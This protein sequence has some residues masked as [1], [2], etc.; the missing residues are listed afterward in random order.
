[1]GSVREKIALLKEKEASNRSLRPVIPPRV[2]PLVRQSSLGSNKPLVPNRPRKTN[3][4]E[5]SRDIQPSKISELTARLN[6][7]SVPSGAKPP[8]AAQVKV[9]LEAAKVKDDEVIVDLLDDD[10]D[11]VDLE[12]D[13]QHL[14]LSRPKLVV[15]RRRP[16]SLKTVALAALCLPKTKSMT[17]VYSLP[18]DSEVD[19][20]LSNEMALSRP[21]INSHLRRRPMGFQSVAI[22]ALRDRV[23]EQNDVHAVIKV[24][25]DE[26]AS[27]SNDSTSD[28]ET[29]LEEANNETKSETKVE[30]QQEDDSSEYTSNISSDD[31]ES[32]DNNSFQDSTDDDDLL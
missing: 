14:S 25:V 10:K 24:I 20:S 1:M 26:I 30:F 31:E 13:M 9:N 27:K 12:E 23:R 29:E 28:V 2:D 6:L 21:K 3:D 18:G 11:N 5:I 15:M 19:S 16:Q 22:A 7:S 32:Q 4:V 17:S 8:A